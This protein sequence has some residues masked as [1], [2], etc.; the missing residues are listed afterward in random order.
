MN[1]FLKKNAAKFTADV[2]YVFE[3]LAPIGSE[4]GLGLLGSND[5]DQIAFRLQFQ[6]LW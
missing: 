2:V 1:W 5:G 3:P 6:L 4:S